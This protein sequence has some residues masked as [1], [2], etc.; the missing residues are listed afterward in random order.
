MVVCERKVWIFFFLRFGVSGLVCFFVYKRFKKN[1]LKVIEG[2]RYVL[3]S[4]FFRND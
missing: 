4:M 1:L 3:E 2:F